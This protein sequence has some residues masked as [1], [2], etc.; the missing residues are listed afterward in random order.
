MTT[1][2]TM[3]VTVR[4]RP[5]MLVHLARHPYFSAVSISLSSAAL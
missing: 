2:M 3:H 1:A 4:K 5:M